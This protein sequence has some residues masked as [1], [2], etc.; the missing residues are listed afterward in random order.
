MKHKKH[1]LFIL[2]AWFIQL[3][4]SA[5]QT[6]MEE[7]NEWYQKK[8]NNTYFIDMSPVF[9]SSKDKDCSYIGIW[10]ENC[11]KINIRLDTVFRD[12]IDI[13]HVEGYTLLK[14]RTDEFE[15]Y[16]KV[17]HFNFLYMS[18]PYI[19]M[20]VAGSYHF[21]EKNNHWEFQGKFIRHFAQYIKSE[22]I[23]TKNNKLG[24]IRDG[25]AGVWVDKTN[26][27]T[28][29][30]FFG[31]HRYPGSLTD[32]DARGGVSLMKPKYK[33]YGWESYYNLEKGK[34][35]DYWNKEC[36]NTWWEE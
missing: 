28:Y 14:N 9:Y 7:V 15:G 25:F 13:Y 2:F 29:D 34:Y 11:Q 35:G 5:Q 8:T 4:V 31:F 16:I 36:G 17:Q 22:K 26:N 32:F 24:E 12:D 27:K 23:S 18:S 30:C 10:G 3:N 33:N 1:V 20:A 6:S 19:V 21:T